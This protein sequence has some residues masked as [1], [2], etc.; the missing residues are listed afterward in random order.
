MTTFSERQWHPTRMLMCD[1]GRDGVIHAAALPKVDSDGGVTSTDLVCAE[2]GGRMALVDVL[3]V[4][5][6]PSLSSISDARTPPLYTTAKL[7]P[8]A[9]IAAMNASSEASSS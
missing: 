2:C 7:N 9:M 4:D 8:V 6:Q 1:G 3:T 5:A